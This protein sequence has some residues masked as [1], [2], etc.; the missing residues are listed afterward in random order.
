[1]GQSGPWGLSTLQRQTEEFFSKSSEGI[2]M[3]IVS[4]FHSFEL[5]RDGQE[6]R[7]GRRSWRSPR[8]VALRRASSWRFSTAT[9]EVE[10]STYT[11]PP[12]YNRVILSCGVCH[13][14]DDATWRDFAEFEPYASTA[15]TTQARGESGPEPDVAEGRCAG[16]M[17]PSGGP[18]LRTDD[19]GVIAAP[20][21]A[22]ELLIFALR[23]RWRLWSGKGT[24]PLEAGD[25]LHAS[26]RRGGGVRA[27][28][29]VGHVAAAARGLGRN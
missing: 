25:T 26:N 17:I 28:E 21:G 6:R 7:G 23:G 4:I 1:M 8:W 10:E 11:S 22:E 15:V 18:G 5:P 16:T 13:L 29:R 20:P 12:D 24:W 9:A 3:S 14:H 27:T 19:G 2:E